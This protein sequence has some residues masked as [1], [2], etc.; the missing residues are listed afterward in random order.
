MVDWVL[1]HIAGTQN[2][3]LKL[4]GVEVI[5]IQYFL[6]EVGLDSIGNGCLTPPHL[7]LG[8]PHRNKQILDHGKGLIHQR[9]VQFLDPVL[10]VRVVS[11]I[12]INL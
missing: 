9:I 5:G 1:Q 4:G 2:V 3:W 11:V 6:E 10:D 12:I 7:D 8:Q